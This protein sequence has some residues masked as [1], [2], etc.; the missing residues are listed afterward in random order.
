MKDYYSIL[1]VSRTASQD[2]IK[3][4]YRKLASVHHPDKGGDT[5]KFQ[6]IEEAYR[7]LSDPAQ[8]QQYDNPQPNFGGFN[9]QQHGQPFDLNNIFNMFG[10]QFNQ[11]Q[12]S[13]PAQARMS[14][15]IQLSDVA[16]GGSRT[17]S[18]G[19]S[20][21][22]QLIEIEIPKGIE[23][24]GTVVYS[25]LAPG[26]VDLAVTFRIHPNPRWKRDGFNLYVEQKVS[27]WTMISGG[28]IIVRDILN[29]EL[30]VHVPAMTQPGQVLRCR[31]RGLP[32]RANNP[33]D[34]MIQ[35]QA[36]IPQNIP[37]ELL[38]LIRQQTGR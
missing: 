16:A 13:R 19:T 8:R 2:E 38:T 17:V 3:R 35:L 27:I 28:D 32:D 20:A 4:A 6:Q 11:H 37:E 10:A 14:L 33:G 9:F 1:N 30:E 36:E 29:R 21:G 15:W 7:I 18:V 5:A 22:S 25:G 12:R 23:D 34:M 24:G 31:G 26:G